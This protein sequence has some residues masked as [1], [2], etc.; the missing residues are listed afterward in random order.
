MVLVKFLVLLFVVAVVAIV[1]VIGR[2]NRGQMPKRVKRKASAA[3]SYPHRTSRHIDLDFTKEKIASMPYILHVKDGA[4][5]GNSYLY[6][7]VD[8][9]WKSLSESEQT[10]TR[11]SQIAIKKLIV[12]ELDKKVVQV[13]TDNKDLWEVIRGF[14][15]YDK[16]EADGDFVISTRADT[17]IKSLL[18]RKRAAE[19]L[20]SNYLTNLTSIAH[21]DNEVLDKIEDKVNELDDRLHCELRRVIL[22]SVEDKEEAEREHNNN[23][24]L[25]TMAKVIEL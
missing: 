13:C 19:E 22:E 12:N 6:P 11:V 1:M 20:K 2:K 10:V 5:F 18:E 24:S 7:Q 8:E 23:L 15:Q 17:E 4:E 3:E 16:K 9:I 21:A 25:E 14:Q